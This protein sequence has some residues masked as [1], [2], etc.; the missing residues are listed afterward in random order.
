MEKEYDYKN[1]SVL[2][3]DDE[4]EVGNVVKSLLRSLGFHTDF[5]E[6]AK[7]AMEQLRN[8]HYS[9]LITDI[10][11]PDMNGIELIKTISGENPEISII[12]MTGYDKDYT[13]MD[14]INAGASDFIAKPFKIDEIEA[15]ITRIL[16]ERSIKEK[17]AMLSITDNL[18]GL[19]NQ[20]HFYNKLR[21]EIERANRQKHN[22]SLIL[23]D[24]N[25]FKVY[26]D[27]YGHLAGDTVL[28]K[29]GKIIQANI[30]DSVDTAFR[31]GGDEFAVILVEADESVVKSISDRLKSE[32]DEVG[33]VSASIGF[34]T[35]SP[36]MKMQ[37]LI[38][39][40]DKRLYREKK[41]NIG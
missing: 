22:L 4:P 34:S 36:E 33:E 16:I 29:S 9:F 2:I 38:N 14:V 23:L 1:E 11:M 20:R 6:S 32:F 28:S 13:Y 31:Y 41:R 39:I 30:R 8:G 15:K 40:A 5:A 18:T 35:Y 25:N 27:K 7:S 10:N 21:E 37:D 3:V 17:L 26:N 24:L 12:A 19:Y